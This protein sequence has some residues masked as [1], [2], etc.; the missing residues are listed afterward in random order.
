MRVDLFDFEL[1]PERIALR[2]ARPRDSARLLHVPG[3]G[4]FADLTVRDLPVNI[5]ENTATTASRVTLSP[6]KGGALSI[7]DA[8]RQLIV[9]ALELHKGNRTKA[10]Q[11]LGISRRTLH[12]KL[13][14]Y[15]LHE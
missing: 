3:Q 14:E 12:R 7:D 15:G 5:R 1:P 8:E 4:D 2:P 6:V 13:N 10:A 11:E 9:R